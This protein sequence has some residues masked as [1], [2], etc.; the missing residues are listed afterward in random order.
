MPRY[1]RYEY[2]SSPYSFNGYDWTQ[3]HKSYTQPKKTEEE[4]KKE[5]EQQEKIAAERK[6]L[7]VRGLPALINLGNTCY[8]NSTLQ[9]LNACSLFS[10]YL[11]EGDFAGKIR[12]NKTEDIARRMRR[13]QKLSDDTAVKIS[14]KML[15]FSCGNAL[16]RHMHELFV[17]M[18]DKKPKLRPEK[19]KRKFGELSSVFSG[20][21]QNDSQELLNLILDTVH[22][23]TKSAVRLKYQNVPPSVIKFIELRTATN[24]ILRDSNV[25]I[26]KKKEA[27]EYYRQYR[28]DHMSDSV[29]LDAYTFWKNHVG[30]SYSVITSLFTGIFCSR[31]ICNKC[32][33]KSHSFEPFTILSVPT[34]EEGEMTLDDC[35]KEFNKEELLIGENQY[36][37]EECGTKTDAVKRMYIW[38]LPSILIIQLKRFK[39]EG[40]R[41]WKTKSKVSY[42]MNDL[43]MK[44]SLID[45]NDVTD[46]KYDLCGVS[47]HRG[48]CNYGHYIAYC[49][50]EINKKWYEFDDEDIFYIPDED[51]EKQIVNENSYILFYVKKK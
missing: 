21:S 26:E 49:K 13:A 40:S 31:I 50:S 25:P 37:C 51:A 30:K 20:Y 5:K 22:E 17:K 47:E 33:T 3:Y 19:L 12:Q 9:C 28:K 41:I 8:M 7:T 15:D 24:D 4:I 2:D 43:D 32:G 38:E 23:E 16:T 44:P 36:N 27:Q 6:K 14:V 18:W 29:I 10:A 34:L 45:W 39:N 1:S 11:R 46:T 35:I 48:A 42:P